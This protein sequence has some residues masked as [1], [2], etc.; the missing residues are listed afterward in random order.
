MSASFL[1]SNLLWVGARCVEGWEVGGETQLLIPKQQHRECPG[2][3]EVMTLHSY[4]QGHGFKP[5]LGN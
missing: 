5:W 2:G 4:C 3:P 1:P